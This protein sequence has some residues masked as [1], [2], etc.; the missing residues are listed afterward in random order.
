[1]EIKC[2]FETLTLNKGKFNCYGCH[3]TEAS[4]TKPG[5]EIN[6]FIGEHEEGKTNNDVTSIWFDNTVVEH[7]PRSFY[8][9]F[10]NLKTLEI[11]NCGLKNI[12][13]KDLRGLENL[14]RLTITY[15]KLRSLPSDLF[16]EMCKLQ[17]ISIRNNNLE[18]M[19]SELL[20]PITGNQL[21]LLNFRGNNKIDATYNPGAKRSVK[22]LQELMEIIDRDCSEP[23]DE[24]EDLESE[25]H[26][27]F[28][29]MWQSNRYSDFLIVGGGGD[30]GEASK[31]FKVHKIVLGF[32]S[33]VFA[34][35]FDNVMEEAQSGKMTIKDFSANV[36]EGMLCYIYTGE[37]QD[38]KDAMDLYAI[39]IKYD[40]AGLK[41]KSH[42]IILRNLE[43]NN[44]LEVFGLGHLH[45]SEQMK[46]VA[47]NKINETF[48]NAELDESLM[49]NPEDLREIVEAR[50][51]R[52]R[53]MEE[54]EVAYQSKM[55]KHSK[56]FKNSTN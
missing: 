35:I 46:R 38:A 13:R 23:N 29:E 32:Q 45:N 34:A 4:I 49:E 50:R 15:N 36:V 22:T 17:R 5:T 6:A 53:K 16:I 27:R 30:Q 47:F 28:K 7:V 54:A 48:P 12:T 20:T 43:E 39:A 31:E 8:K 14:E 10:P 26:G 52:K 55:E 9:I 19:S 2:I 44:A 56:K 11:R 24:K 25:F 41:E 33:P 37:I 51:D 42:Q 40:I 3:I 18:F 1:M 21:K